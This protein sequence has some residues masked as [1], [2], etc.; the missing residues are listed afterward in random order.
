MNKP[1][2]MNGQQLLGP[3]RKRMTSTI[4]RQRWFLIDGWLYSQLQ[5]ICAQGHGPGH[6]AHLWLCYGPKKMAIFFVGNECS[7][8]GHKRADKQYLPSFAVFCLHI[9][10]RSR[11]QHLQESFIMSLA[12]GGKSQYSKNKNGFETW[13]GFE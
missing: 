10:Y 2:L 3:F 7:E 9:L 6:H 12:G 4:R 5:N 11:S 8:R 1:P 13:G